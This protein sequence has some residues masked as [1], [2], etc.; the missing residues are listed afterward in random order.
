MVRLLH[1]VLTLTP[2]LALAVLLDGC[3]ELSTQHAGALQSRGSALIAIP[4]DATHEGKLFPGSGKETARVVAAAFRRHVQ[5]VE[6]MSGTAFSSS[7]DSSGASRFDYL[8]I[9]MIIQWEDRTVKKHEREDFVEIGIRVLRA[10][11][12]TMLAEWRVKK[13]SKVST[14]FNESPAEQLAES[15]EEHV[16]ELFSGR[17]R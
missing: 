3:V 12:G 9:P 10:R 2:A 14:I 5:R 13:P 4:L 8:V 17:E 16:S 6:I 15:I 11:D 7:M 1:Q